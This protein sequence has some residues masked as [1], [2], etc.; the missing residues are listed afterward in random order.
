MVRWVVVAKWPA[1]AAPRVGARGLRL[2]NGTLDHDVY[3]ENFS[4]DSLSALGVRFARARRGRG[5]PDLG[6]DG[7]FRLRLTAGMETVALSAAAIVADETCEGT[8]GSVTE[9]LTN[10]G[11]AG[12]GGAGGAAALVGAGRGRGLEPRVVAERAAAYSRLGARAPAS[13]GGALA[14][15]A[16]LPLF[17]H[18]ASPEWA[19]TESTAAGGQ[20]T[21]STFCKT[22]L[23]GDDSEVMRTDRERIG[24][25]RFSMTLHLYAGPEAWRCSGAWCLTRIARRRRAPRGRPGLFKRQGH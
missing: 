24:A 23:L 18:P 15:A 8:A 1:L 9:L 21:A 22:R 10:R 3:E 6:K 5:G 11:A 12:L 19:M 20:E 7:G 17:V 4:G 13:V 16:G 2:L 14:A 25:T